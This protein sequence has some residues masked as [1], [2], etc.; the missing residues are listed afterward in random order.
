MFSFQWIEKVVP[1][2]P[3]ISGK[4]ATVEEEEEEKE[5]E[6]QKKT[7]EALPVEPKPELLPQGKSSDGKK[8]DETEIKAGIV[9]TELKCTNVEQVTEHDCGKRNAAGGFLAW[10][11]QGLVR[12][13]PQP[14]GCPTPSCT[15]Q[16]NSDASTEQK[17]EE[18]NGNEIADILLDQGT[19]RAGRGMLSWFMQGLEKMIPQPKEVSTLTK[20]EDI[21]SLSVSPSEDRVKGV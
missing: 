16:S 4:T 21:E 3:V 9:T 20:P 6:K 7:E 14:S 2:P 8:I 1:Q 19:N 18:Q 11:T 10:L 15:I 13:I 12:V 5:K 17:K